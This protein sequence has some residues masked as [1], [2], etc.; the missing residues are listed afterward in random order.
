MST[1][2][3]EC[4]NKSA[5]LGIR[6]R[7]ISVLNSPLINRGSAFTLEERAALGLTGLLP[8]FVTTLDHQA[9]RV[10]AQYQRQPDDLRK[11]IYLNA[12][13]DRN[14]VLF[15]RLLLDHL[16]EM[17]PIIYT[18]TVGVAIEQY[19]H[20]YQR[21]GGIYLSIDKPD[22][23]EEAFRNYGLGSEDVDLIV[24]T[25]SEQILG[26]GDWGVGGIDIAIGKLNVYTAA[27]GIDPSRVIPIVLDVGT[28]RETL[29]NDPFYLGNR[30]PRV[31]GDR[32][33]EFVDSYVKTAARC[34]PNAIL[35][36]EDFGTSTGRTI[37]DKY[38]N[39]YCTFNDDIQ[40]TG[41]M[42]VAALLSAIRVT[43]TSLKEQR[44]VIFGSGSAGIGIADHIRTAMESAG[45]SSKDAHARFWCC[46]R[47]GLLTDDMGDALRDFQ[48]AYARSASEVRDWDGVSFLETVRRVQPTLL[49]G[50]ST[51]AGA[52]DEQIV[53]TMA[54]HVKRPVIFPLSNP[55]RL[56]E[57][58]PEQLLR[59]TDGRAL[60]ATGSPFGPVK[61]GS[62]QYQIGQANNALLFPGLGLG[63]I[64][65]RASRI[66]DGMFAAAS[67][68]LAGIVDLSNAGAPLLPDLENLRAVSQIVAVAVVKAAVAEG[69]ARVPIDDPIDQ[70]WR[71][72]WQPVYRPVKAI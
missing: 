51:V 70:V 43:G 44:V 10:Y 47:K 18:P 32:Y 13:R 55:T 42:V 36:W 7:G 22:E 64:V 45:L 68:A 61:H 26:I 16:R 53:Q 11:N 41:A 5:E 46:G 27:A 14:E 37:L 59:W 67:T 66:S 38:R 4:T 25:D 65:S 2:S 12:L 33:M 15:Y 35:H 20:E 30:H 31:R 29:L 62:I 19:S 71:S 23:I 28:N 72:M 48:V 52:F 17:L 63:T 49:I 34:F 39:D 1:S 69:L 57:A 58:T 54:E 24:A 40:G 50:T 6:S 56:A 3:T 21:P 60:V 8:P 9:K